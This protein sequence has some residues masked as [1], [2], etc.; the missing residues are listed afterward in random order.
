MYVFSWICFKTSWG[1]PSHSVKSLTLPVAFRAL[2]ELTPAYLHSLAFISH[3]PYIQ[4]HSL[5]F[6]FL[7]L[8]SLRPVQL[9]FPLP[10]MCVSCIFTLLASLL[11]LKFCINTVCLRT[12]HLKCHHSIALAL[13]I[14]LVICCFSLHLGVRPEGKDFI[15]FPSAS[16]A[17]SNKPET[18]GTQ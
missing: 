8:P 14:I 12:P 13:F 17:S 6:C 11:H 4:P 15:L 1:V 9:L 10:G 7:H 5:P 18:A 3:P 16:L 2:Q